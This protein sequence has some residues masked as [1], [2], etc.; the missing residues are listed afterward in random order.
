MP[1]NDED[2][3]SYEKAFSQL[4]AIV[5]RLEDDEPSLDDLVKDYEKGMKLLK[6]C[7]DRLNEAALRIEKVRNDG[8][9]TLQSIDSG[10]ETEKE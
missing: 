1:E 9:I 3:L 4:E 6:T 7:H 10:A 2:S 5:A 8:E